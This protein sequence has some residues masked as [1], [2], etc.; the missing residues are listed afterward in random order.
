MTRKNLFIA[1]AFGVAIGALAIGQSVLQGATEAMQTVE[2]PRFEVDPVW[3]KPLPNHWVLGNV[4]GIGIDS[5]DH[6]FIVHRNDTADTLDANHFAGGT[7]PDLCCTPAPPVIE[8]DPAGNVVA[9]WGGPPADKSY[10]WPASNH[11]IG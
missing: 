2:A 8:F 5:R 7:S 9:A 4:I 1:A 11:G 3:P 10:V 6:V